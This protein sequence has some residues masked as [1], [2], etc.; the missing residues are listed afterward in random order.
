L[1]C[2]MPTP[3]FVFLR[4]SVVIWATSKNVPRSKYSDV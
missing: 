1:L 2:K 4:R 3:T